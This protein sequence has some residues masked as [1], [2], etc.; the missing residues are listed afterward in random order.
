LNG[1]SAGSGVTG[2]TITAGNS[3]L[4][5]LIVNRFRFDGVQLSGNGGNT[6]VNCYS[7]TNT[8]AS[9]ASANLGV[10]IYVLNS[11]NN[12]IGAAT[13]TGAGGGTFNVRN[14]IS[15]NNADGLFVESTGASITGNVIKNNYIGTNLG[16]SGPVGNRNSGIVIGNNVTNTVI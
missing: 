15:G 5:G 9:A 14:I 1:S 10:G 7:G 6:T 16:G 4:R 2:L 8:S 3:S 11:G 13:F 12:T